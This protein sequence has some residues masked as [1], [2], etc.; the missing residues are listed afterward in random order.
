MEIFYIF[1]I[2]NIFFGGSLDGL[3]STIYTLLKN[4]GLLCSIFLHTYIFFLAF[5][6]GIGFYAFHKFMYDFA[7]NKKN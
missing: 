5:F 2:T 1:T 6:D 3:I 4:V 7:Q